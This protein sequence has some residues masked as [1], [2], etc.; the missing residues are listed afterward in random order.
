MRR[1]DIV[2]S[3]LLMTLLAIA[4]LSLLQ[5]VSLQHSKSVSLQHS[6]LV[7]GLLVVL[8]SVAVAL[9]AVDWMAEY[10]HCR[11]IR[12]ATQRHYLIVVLTVLWLFEAI[13]FS[14]YCL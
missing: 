8:I 12:L 5:S 9:D 1:I 4:I 3:L 13:S 7:D 10:V 14:Y 2:N 11:S 6:I